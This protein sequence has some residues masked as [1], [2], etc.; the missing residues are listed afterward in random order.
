[1][2]Q[3]LDILECKYGN[4][5]RGRWKPTSYAM[6]MKSMWLFS[7][8]SIL[9]VDT[10]KPRHYNVYQRLSSDELDAL[11]SEQ[12]RIITGYYDGGAF[13]HI[14]CPYPMQ[15]RHAA[16]SNTLEAR[17]YYEDISAWRAWAALTNT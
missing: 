6:L 3:L 13:I 16:T 1:M 5:N 17:C 11:H 15:I 8:L 9:G 14:P 12:S 2:E 10:A 7:K 4:K